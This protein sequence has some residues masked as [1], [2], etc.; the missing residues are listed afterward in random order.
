VSYE[1]KGLMCRDC[2]APFT[3]TAG[4]QEFFAQR[5]LLNEPGRCPECR[6]TRKRQGGGRGM[7]EVQGYGGGGGEYQRA[8]REMYEAMCAGCGGLARVPFQPTGS[9]PVYCSTCFEAQRSYR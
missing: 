7:G 2:G 1:D 8:P 9:K 5:G 3:F 4:E 6:A